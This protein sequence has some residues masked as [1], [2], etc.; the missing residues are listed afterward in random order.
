MTRVDVLY[1]I[2]AVGTQILLSKNVASI[3][4]DAGDGTLRDLIA[5]K[6]DFDTLKA[7]LLT[8]EHF[9]HIS[10]LYSLVNFLTLLG[11]TEPLL[12]T[13]PRPSERAASI[14]RAPMMYYSPQFP[15]SLVELSDGDEKE[16][17][18]WMIRAFGV[19]H[20]SSRSIGYSILDDDGFRV[21]ISGDTQRCTNLEREVIGADIAILECTFENKDRK[22]AEEYGHMVRSDA[23]ALG[24]SAKQFL[25]IHSSPEGYFD[26]I[27]CGGRP[28]DH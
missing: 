12:I 10:G 18:D 14:L 26:K 17:G 5:R 1:S 16:I 7:V 9:D 21:V 11:R 20:A 23:E 2:S 6:F 19:A 24:R 25:L 27:S 15:I 8:H 4:V 28:K 3:L 22:L 13:S